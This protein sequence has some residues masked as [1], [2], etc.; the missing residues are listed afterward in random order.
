MSATHQETV[1]VDLGG[2]RVT[3]PKGGLFDRY[4][5]DTDLDEVARDSRVSG[6]DFFRRLPKTR[7]DSPIGSTLTPNF[8]YRMSSARLTMLARSRAIRA[9]LPREL[10]PLEV[11]PGVGLASVIFFRYEV[12][13]IDFYTEAAVGVAVRP[14]RHGRLGAVDLAAALKNDHLDTYVLSLPVNTDIA[15]VRGHDG[16]GFPK[17]VTE[18]DVDIDTRRAAAR[19]VGDSGETDVAFSAPTPAQTR[20]P[21]GERVSTLTSYTSIA[22]AWHST[23]SQT[24]VLSAGSAVLPRGV[25]LRLGKGRMT[26]DLRSLEPIRTIR[27]DVITEGQLALH[28]PVPYSVPSAA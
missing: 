26:D 6:V 12:C 3:V 15:Q 19:V 23:L 2:R 9:R 1:E 25:D 14:A 4:R 20:Y 7:V 28:M 10:A 24:N 17:W 13:D 18:L 8:Y 5:M 16:Y 11:V 22:G 21:S 27:L